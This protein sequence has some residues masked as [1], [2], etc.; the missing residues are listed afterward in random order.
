[1]IGGQNISPRL[2]SN[3]KAPTSFENEALR[4]IPTNIDDGVTPPRAI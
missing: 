1:M 2:S 3:E 4:F